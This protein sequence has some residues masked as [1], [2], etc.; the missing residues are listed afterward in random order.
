VPPDS[1]DLGA[2]AARGAVGFGALGLGTAGLGAPAGTGPGL[3]A[4][5]LGAVGRGAAGFTGPGRGAAG[6]A[7]PPGGPGRG[8]VGRGAAGRGPPE[9]AGP[10]RGAAGRGMAAPVD[11]LLVCVS[12]WPARELLARE[13]DPPEAPAVLEP[14]AADVADPLLLGSADVLAGEGCVA[15]DP[16]EVAG[17]GRGCGRLAVA[18][19]VRAASSRLA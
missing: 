6:L 15:A 17:A 4:A 13:Y 7:A 11:P 16:A 9:G 8:A 1:P 19:A 12:A 10:G 5:G 18:V 2:A 3:G 14:P